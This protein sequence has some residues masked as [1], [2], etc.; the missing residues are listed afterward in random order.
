MSSHR[1]FRFLVAEYLGPPRTRLGSRR[2]RTE[3]STSKYKLWDLP[4]MVRASGFVPSAFPKDM[5]FRRRTAEVAGVWF[6][7]A[8][9]WKVVA[10]A[11]CG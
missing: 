5:T 4:T 1:H 6:C 8:A 11:G 9:A 7:G 2:V 10:S 3:M